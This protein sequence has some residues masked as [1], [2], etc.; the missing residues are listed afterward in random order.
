LLVF[1]DAHWA[2][3]TSLELIDLAIERVRRL[4]VLALFTYRPEFEP[5]WVGLPNVSSMTLGRLSPGD[6]QIMVAQTTDGRALPV[7]V[8]QQILVKTG[9]NPLFGEELTKAVLESGILVADADGYRLAGPLPPLAIPATLHDSLMARLDR[10]GAV[11][12]IAQGAAAIGREFSFALI[13]ALFE[14]YAG[15]LE[16]AL[17]Q[18]E[19]AGL[20]FRRGAPPQAI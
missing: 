19:R 18:L 9:G 10:L 12:E 13:S 2:D 14:S 7:E 1:E 5:P 20:V 8:M 3:A 4:P 6:A 15:S 11:K 17:A 16:E